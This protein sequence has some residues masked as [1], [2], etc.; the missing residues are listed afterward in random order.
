MDR[1]GFLGTN[2]SVAADV[3]LL[4]GI[5]IALLLTLGV[6]MAVRR[7]YSTHRWIQST[8]VVLNIVQ[9]LAIMVGSFRRSAEPGIPE[10][11]GQ[12]YYLVVTLHAAIGSIALLLGAFVALR[13]NELVP[14]FLKFNNYKL[15][16]RSAYGL[17]MLATL[18][19][20]WTYVTWYAGAPAR[21]ALPQASPAAAQPQAPNA[22]AAAATAAAQPVAQSTTQAVPMA[23]FVFQPVELVIPAGTTVEWTNQDGAPHTATADD[24]TLFKSAT[25]GTGET[26]SFSFD[27]PGEYAYYCELHGSPGGIGMAGKIRVVE[28]G[29]QPQQAAAEPAPVATPAGGEA[30]TPLPLPQDLFGQPAG[31]AAF[32]DVQAYGDSIELEL[33]TGDAPDG[34]LAA[35]LLSAQ[36]DQILPLGELQ[37]DGELARL[38]YV[39]P[40]GEQLAGRFARLLVTTDAGF[41]VQPSGQTVYEATLPPLAFEQLGSLVGNG[42]GGTGSVV[43][44]RQQVDELARHIGLLDQSQAAG[45]LEG[46]RRHGEHVYNLI[47]GSRDARFGDLDGD[48]R[49]QNPGDGFGLL[50]N[51]DQNG[52]IAATREAALAAA[53]STD[54]TPSIVTHGGHV[55]VCADNLQAWAE[56]ARGLALQITEAGDTAA[57]SD[58]VAR[59]QTLG[60][61]I[62]R[63]QDVDGNGLLTPVAGEG[64]GLVAYEHAVYMTG[65]GLLRSTQ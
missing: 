23:D 18:A 51:G 41:A 21:A 28:P 52:Y 49:S 13:G 8:A 55:A 27:T 34:P 10:R 6:V 46:V 11:L 47:A 36:S 44:L 4:A 53:E 40:G 57:T 60:R 20:I 65:F 3:S 31:T 5:F 59:L 2:A 1:R 35:F 58:A 9:V 15:W 17:Y 39:A 45:D 43:K 64:G 33:Q 12:P 61:W 63:G 26:F 42:A 14:R 50:L 25:L 38:T 24:G 16:M 48:G 29:Q 37:R 22:S 56:E 19:G 7:R 32:R 30:P 62:Q 54:A